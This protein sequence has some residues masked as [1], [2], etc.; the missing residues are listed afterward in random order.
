MN[1]KTNAAPRL[2]SIDA[3]RGLVMVLLAFNGFGI[4][5]ASRNF[6]NSEGW[7]TAGW[8]FDH[9]A[10]RGCSLWDMI[11]PSF[12]FLVGVSIPWSLASQK[13]NGV[14]PTQGWLRAV[15][16]SALLIVL[17]IFL[18]SNNKPATDFSFMNVLTQIGLGYLVVYAIAQSPRPLAPF[19]AAGILLGYGML[20]AFWPVGTP[21]EAA[22]L[23]LPADRQQLPG[24]AAHW[25]QHLNPAAS[26][27]RWFLNFFPR[28]AP[29]V[30][31][32]GGYQTL[33]FIPS[34]ATMLLGLAAGQSIKETPGAFPVAIRLVLGGV[35]IALLGW[36]LDVFGI[37][38]MVKRIW[39]P[40]W[41]LWSG[42]LCLSILGLFHFLTEAAQRRWL[43][44]PL[45][46]AGM[47]SIV[48]YVLYMLLRPW[49]AATWERH[50]GAKV[51]LVAGAS[52]API[53]QACA[54]GLSF[55]LFVWW[56]ARQK[57]FIRL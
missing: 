56:L 39:T 36:M 51:F 12:M 23:G 46:I 34:I 47:N 2:A 40:S 26:F 57:V 13:A 38:P 33:N 45:G 41:T 27:D 24:F 9:V 52:L 43:V 17:G 25:N 30:F 22:M 18:I 50:L 15:A 11:Q 31:N 5:D 1:T 10:W 54:V 6:P 7:Q 4:L 32:R 49:M 53:L 35:V 3:Y 19:V 16:R 20:F 28:E 37:C 21:E 44:W 42:G 48:L 8:L 55:W 14:T 29:F